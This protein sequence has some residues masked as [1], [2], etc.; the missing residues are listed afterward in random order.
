MAD[1]TPTPAHTVTAEQIAQLI[2]V[3]AWLSRRDTPKGGSSRGTS[4]YHAFLGSYRRSYPALVSLAADGELY[5]ETV[6]ELPIPARKDSPAQWIMTRGTG[7]KA[8]K[9]ITRHHDGMHRLGITD[10]T[11][12]LA[13]IPGMT[14]NDLVKYLTTFDDKIADKVKPVR[15]QLAQQAERAEIKA[16]A[17]KALADAEKSRD[18]AKKAGLPT[19]AFDAVI[20]AYREQLAELS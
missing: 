4:N 15:E 1:A 20:K 17:E 14:V 12:P 9:L 2:P 5:G 13:A 16:E 8:E 11:H 7:A 19:A 18:R 6:G 10:E 3:I